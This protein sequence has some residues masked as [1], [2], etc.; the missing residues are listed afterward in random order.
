ME[1]QW[2]NTASKNQCTLDLYEKLARDHDAEWHH[3]QDDLV[4][5]LKARNCTTYKGLSNAIF[6]WCGPK[7]IERWL[8]TH[9]SYHMYKKCILPGLTA[10]NSAKQVVFSRHVHAHWD[11]EPG[12]KVLWIMVISQNDTF[13]LCILIK[14]VL[15]C[16]TYLFIWVA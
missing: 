8:K 16:T 11:L 6:G 15:L 3:I 7:A 2:H 1:L 5:I 14:S 4:T 10:T 13:L 12:T 9:E